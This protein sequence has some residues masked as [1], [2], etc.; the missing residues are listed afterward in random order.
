MTSH[1]SAVKR[2]PVGIRKSRKHAGGA[3]A[4]VSYKIPYSTTACVACHYEYA[5]DRGHHSPPCPKCRAIQ[6]LQAG[7]Q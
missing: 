3:S 6:P 5:V 4:G 7:W 2:L 1:S